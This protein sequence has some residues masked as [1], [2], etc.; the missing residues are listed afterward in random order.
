MENL[1]SRRSFLAMQSASRPLRIGIVGV[2]E[3][4]SYHLDVLLGMDNVEV[5]ALCDVDDGFLYRGKKWVT[6]AGKPAPEQWAQWQTV[7]ESSAGV[8]KR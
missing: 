6:D 3:R 4:G 5:K 1:F 2:G 7:F 8:P